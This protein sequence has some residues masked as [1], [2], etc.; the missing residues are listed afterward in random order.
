MPSS[1]SGHLPR[2]IDWSEAN[3]Q[4][5]QLQLFESE[6]QNQICSLFAQALL[7]GL[8]VGKESRTAKLGSSDY[9]LTR[10]AHRFLPDKH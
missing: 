8:K 2:A 7:S 4:P 1:Q 3:L 6:R 10:P 5:L 9:L